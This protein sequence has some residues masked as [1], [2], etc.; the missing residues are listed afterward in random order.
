MTAATLPDAAAERPPLPA[1]P[2]GEREAPIGGA[3]R[4]QVDALRAIAIIAVV[5]DHYLGIHVFTNP[6][7]VGLQFFFV[8][9]GY[10]VTAILLRAKE[11]PTPLDAAGRKKALGGFYARR[12]L[13]I[14]PAWLLTVAVA[15]VLASPAQREYLGWHLA[16]LSNFLFSWLDREVPWTLAPVW[17]LSNQEQFY[18]IWPLV[19][20]WLSRRGITAAIIAMVAMSLVFRGYAVETGLEGHRASHYLPFWPMILLAVGAAL[21]L[22]HSRPLA[23]AESRWAP[24]MASPQPWLVLALAATCLTIDWFAR[25]AGI[26]LVT[27]ALWVLPLALLLNGAILGY[28]GPLGRLLDEKVLQYFGQISLG[29]YLFHMPL[30]VIAG[31]ALFAVTGDRSLMHVGPELLAVGLPLTLLAAVVSWHLMESPIN[32]FKRYFP[33]R[34]KAPKAAPAAEAQPAG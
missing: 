5:I 13:R 31:R 20:L 33:Y 30:M 10:L 11:S 22:V 8:A 1:A 23:W 28:T 9:S 12:A 14:M 17:T 24:V 26:Y 7:L 16:F 6:G 18:L 21:A 3:R 27:S 4:K 34:T 32:E 19:V 2:E 29:I 25:P 15:H